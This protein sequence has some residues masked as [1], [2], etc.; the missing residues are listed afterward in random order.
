MTPENAEIL[1]S[2]KPTVRL[3]VMDL[4]SEAGVDVSSWA[5]RR[6]G[7]PVKDPRANPHY[8]YDWAFGSEE[9][10]FVLCVWHSTLQEIQLPSGAALGYQENLRAVALDLDRVAIDRGRPSDE[11]NRARDQASRARSF[12]SAVQRSFRR[13]QGLRFILNDGVRRAIEELGIGKSSV[14]L[15]CLDTADWYVHSYDDA[16]GESLLV[17]GVPPPGSVAADDLPGS[18]ELSDGESL[19]VGADVVPNLAE[20]PSYVDQ[21]SAPSVV[22]QREALVIVRERSAAVR[23]RVLRRARG[24]CE[25]CGQPGFVTGDGSIYLETHH[26]LPLALEGPDHE[27]NMVALCPNDHR[28]AHYGERREALFEELQA[29]ALGKHRE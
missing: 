18:V 26:V 23:A 4:V 20:T 7:A 2:L 25:L 28:Q 24:I 17:R 10:G 21:F 14:K 11:R 3:A 6:D 27:S 22:A 15:R 13:G 9:E 5:I 16:T 19:E 12:D 8:C 1:E 29:L